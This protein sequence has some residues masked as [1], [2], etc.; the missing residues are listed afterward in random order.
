MSPFSVYTSKSMSQK[1]PIY[2]YT[3]DEGGYFINEYKEN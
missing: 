3:I 1:N 2:I